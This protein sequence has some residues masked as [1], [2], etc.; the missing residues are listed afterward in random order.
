M[1]EATMDRTGAS[2]DGDPTDTVWDLVRSLSRFATV[3]TMVGLRC[4]DHLKDGP[5]TVEELA[6]RCGAKAGGL[7]RILRM[8]AAL[9]LTRQIAPGTYEL[10]ESGMTL[11]E[12][13]PNSMRPAVLVNAEVGSWMATNA[14]LET[15]R[16][17]R[18]YMMEHGSYYDYLAARPAANQAF[19]EFMRLRTEPVAAAVASGY[20][21]S[22]VATLVDVGGGKGTLIAAILRAH[23]GVRGILLDRANVIPDAR[24]NLSAHGLT[25][26]CELMTGDFFSTV[27]EGADA[28]VLASIIHNWGD[29]DALR[30][31][32]TVRE[33]MPD[34]GRILLVDITLPDDD[35]PHIGKEM[36]VRMLTMFADGRERTESEYFDLL[37]Q[38]GLRGRVVAD[39]PMGLSLVE[40]L[41]TG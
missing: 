26:R 13:A 23:P 2:P 35:R 28:Y 41:P 5:L 20:D 31:L 21:F 32:S 7:G 24:V 30:I 10:T 34:D 11:C 39:L 33:A 29:E 1:S 36:D 17:G 15:V 8:A 40:A 19:N 14:V 25:D 18:G 12:D 4:A 22:D 27:P 16:T 3:H 9:G 38:A 37:K 6:D